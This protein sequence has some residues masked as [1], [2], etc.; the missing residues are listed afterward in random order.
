MVRGVKQ[1][2]RWAWI[3]G[4]LC[5]FSVVAEP[6]HWAY[7][8]VQPK[9]SPEVEGAEW[10]HHA[11]DRFVKAALD[12]RGLQAAGVAGRSDWLRRVTYDLTGLPPTVE[13]VRIF[14]ADREPDYAGVVD[15]L[16]NTSHFG[17]RWGRMWLDVVRYADSNG[18]DENKAMSHAWRYRDWVVQAF[19][20]DLPYDDFLRHQLAGDLITGGSEAEQHDRLIATGFLAL[21]PKI[22]AEQD[23]EKMIMDI[24]DEQI[25]TVGRAMLGSTLGCAR[26]HDHKFD[27]ISARDYYALA[28]IFHSTRTML[29]R[30]FVSQ[31]NESDISTA[32]Q[33]QARVDH[34]RRK[35]ENETALAE[36]I[37][38]A[39]A[40][41][42]DRLMEEG[43]AALLAA[44]KGDT[45]AWRVL[46]EDQAVD[47]PL[48]VL[49]GQALA[50]FLR[51]LKGAQA[52]S[53]FAPGFD[54][55]AMNGAS[56]AVVDVAHRPELEPETFTIE[57]RVKL[58][59]A[60]KSE[61]DNRRWLV[62]KNQN[63]W[64]KG[65]YALYLSGSQVGAYIS[66]EGGQG[67]QISVEGAEGAVKPGD[68]V[69][70]AMRFDGR[71]LSVW[72]NGLQQG[73]VAVPRSRQANTF[74]L[75]LGGRADGYNY[76]EEG[77]L[78]QVRMY[79][80]GLD[81]VEMQVRASAHAKEIETG[82]ILREDFEPQNAADRRGAAFP[83][84]ASTLYGEKGL[85]SI[86]RER[87][88][89]ADELAVAALEAER[90]QLKVL[91]LQPMAIAVRDGAV[92]PLPVFVR[93][94]HLAREAEVVPRGFPAALSPNVAR[95]ALPADTSGRRELVEWLLADHPLTARV[96]V[97]R[98]WQTMIAQ[99][100]VRQPDNF[101]PS[102][103]APTHADLL[104][105][106]AA[107]LVRVDWSTKALIRQIALSRTY[108][109]STVPVNEASS[110]RDPD[111]RW[112]SRMPAKRMSA[113]M[114]RD[115]LFA[116]SGQLDRTAGGFV[117][118][119]KN[120]D[121]VRNEEDAY[122][123]NRRALY[124]PVIR[125]RVNPMLTT[126]DFSNASVSCS[127]RQE[128]VVAQQ[129]LFFLNAPLVTEQAGH[130]AKALIQHEA[131][132]TARMDRAYLA[133]FG[134]VATPREREQGMAFLEAHP[135][136]DA[137]LR[138]TDYCQVLFA[139]NE[140]ITLN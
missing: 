75:R 43:V 118:T 50:R 58:N 21:G 110:Q 89:D 3:L 67:Q 69:H 139:A 4:V 138:W 33:R 15:R 121:Y 16:L 34:E 123:S 119:F 45:N 14:L 49:D 6:L 25:D 95:T 79:N 2:Q 106:L 35:K 13:E 126:F 136:P 112:L 131:E 140:F 53:R 26:C 9:A 114:I 115:S 5:T 7:Q 70:V 113:E 128:S 86:S 39:N 132:P 24:I 22:L 127:R 94:D 27:P 87:W 42:S 72:V 135:D 10:G 77:L 109:M 12:Q 101:G 116:I 68:W 57:A 52:T 125:D 130:W 108:R 51:D 105:W 65:H 134:R 28:G 97:N 38:L 56:R 76:F 111:A 20:R 64:E 1:R 100:L 107:D 96:W 55:F 73:E 84:L 40:T 31:W 19:N 17:E 66:P 124:L 99:A 88:A 92:K 59:R 32:E 29:N 98:I 83:V 71:M 30:D 74:P 90:D 85:L 103:E 129:A 133:V 61:G 78:D 11:I 46:L 48:R 23:K 120:A 104:D 93:G 8:P 47:S 137:L 41:L 37:G 60:L 54:G 81:D 82:C 18:Q 62:N 91:P 80:R 117:K 63:E 122:G 102:G 36:R 44:R